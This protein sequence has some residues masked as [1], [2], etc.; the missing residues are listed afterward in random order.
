MVEEIVYDV[1]L[2][3][4]S[5]VG[6]KG[7]QAL[8]EEFGSAKA[9]LTSSTETLVGKGVKPAI[10]KSLTNISNLERAQATVELCN[11]KGVQILVHQVSDN[12]P[13]L[14]TECPDAP[15]VLYQ[16]GDINL[17]L[18][19]LVSIVG[20]RK[21]TEQGIE[22]TI[23]V[24]KEL[25]ES[26]PD[27]VIVSGLAYGIDK[28]AHQAALKNNVPTVAFLPG[29]V[30]DITPAVHRELAREIIRGGG[31]ILS[32]MP[33]ATIVVKGSFLSR[34]RL[35][36]GISS[37]T[38]VVESPERGGSTNTATV[39]ASYNRAVFALPGR[40]CDMNS[41]GTNQLIKTS[42]AILYQDC[43]DLATELGWV[44]KTHKEVSRDTIDEL[45]PY[46]RTAYYAV[47]EVETTTLDEISSITG[48]GLAECCSALIQLE[49]KGLVKSIPGGLYMRN[50]F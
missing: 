16:Y 3:Y 25:A 40:S 10:A 22:N 23:T 14:L 24:V 41:Y 34:N 37:A 17:N 18:H 29:W 9:I 13:T 19:R 15:H 26:Y 8:I 21:A 27:I 48:K 6:H 31:A 43:S 12:Y 28:T 20:T 36:A 33:P 32:D 39:A 38:I 4:A 47:P 7:A 50:R 30:F 45:T 5:G 46:L 42:R 44:R 35:I 11:E 2:T 1:A 49:N